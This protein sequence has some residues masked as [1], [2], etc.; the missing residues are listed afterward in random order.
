MFVE[1]KPAGDGNGLMEAIS[2]K[3]ITQQRILCH[4]YFVTEYIYICEN[5]GLEAILVYWIL[6]TGTMRQIKLL[7]FY[8][9]CNEGT[10]R[11]VIISSAP[12]MPN[13]P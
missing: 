12:G 5:G 1:D 2:M 8:S 13:R 4:R 7:I 11:R 10:C 6:D 9:K 3:S